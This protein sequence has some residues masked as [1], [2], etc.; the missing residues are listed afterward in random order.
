MGGVRLLLVT[1]EFPPMVGGI[2]D[3]SGHLST[4]LAARGIDVGVLTH[5]D[6]V[7]ATSHSDASITMLAVPGWSMLDLPLIKETI[8]SFEPDLIHIQYQ[9]AAFDLG[10]AICVLPKLL[11]IAAV[12][13][14]HDVREPYLFPKAGR[15]RREAN[16]A[17]AR[18]SKSAICTNA[19]DAASVRAFG[20]PDVQVIPLGNNV[21][22]NPPSAFD[23]GARR[24]ELGAGTG[25]FLV[26]HFGL[27][28]ATKG[29]DTLL[30]A[31]TELPDCRV[32]FVGAGEGAAD[33]TNRQAH[34]TVLDQI[35]RRNLAGRV[36]WT[37][38]RTTQE[39]SADLL[40][41]DVL[42][43]PYHEGAS[44][45]RTTLVAALA[46]GIPVISTLPP[47][48]SR[49]FDA[50]DGLP[51]LRS[52]KDLVLVPPKDSSALANAIRMLTRDGSLACR[53]GEAGRHAAAA[54][55]W[56]DVAARHEAL[57]RR[58]VD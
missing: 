40:A 31:L 16:A 53:I 58:L 4:A 2:S 36:S 12:T 50:V 27:M 49:A 38:Q 7:K 46:H 37:G 9:T 51:T 6:A 55:D 34:R 33:P 19:D 54:F 44:F 3:Y 48:G 20:Q 24:A 15:L 5:L 8:D 35:E 21:P 26:G 18:W 11:A 45:R 39:L 52:C 57:Y 56:S 22:M 32:A 28:G 1:G 29:V 17:L 41:C 10:G 43:L 42:A 47:E 14:F 25:D 23:R 13:T 30:D